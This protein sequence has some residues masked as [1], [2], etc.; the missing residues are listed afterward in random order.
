MNRV[1]SPRKHRTAPGALAAVAARGRHGRDPA[2]GEHSPPRP[3]PRPPSPTR[4][5]GRWPRRS[6]PPSPVADRASP[7]GTPH[8]ATR[9]RHAAYPQSDLLPTFVPGGPT[10]TLGG[11]TE[12]NVAVNSGS[13]SV[14]YASGVVGSPGPLEDYC[15]PGSNSAEDAGTPSRQ[16]SGTTLP[17]SPYYFPHIVRNADG[18][19]T[20][21]FDW[22]PEGR[23]RGHRRRRLHRRRK[24]LDLR[25]RGPGAEPELLP[26]RRH[27]RRRPGPPAG[28]HHRWR[29][30]TCTP[31]SGRRA[32]TSTCRCWPTPSARP[33][34]DPLSSVPATEAVGLDA[35][36]FA[37]G[38]DPVT[39]ATASTI[40][41]GA[42]NSGDLQSNGDPGSPD[43]LVPGPVVDLTQTPTPTAARSS[44][45]RG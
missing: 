40:T 7:R 37:T 10:T 29:P 2:G 24:G 14:P 4:R 21:Y 39:H 16:P 38:S 36:A 33:R 30:P 13:G 15:G 5:A 23:R 11:V 18:S 20:G 28:P 22:R 32:T 8:R 45:A 27:E 44:R 9:P 1:R 34:A 17:M 6:W 42:T 43:E 3:P 35:D 25:G 12:P 26:E 41:V 31:C 19:L